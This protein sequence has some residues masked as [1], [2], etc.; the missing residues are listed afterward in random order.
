MGQNLSYCYCSKGQ[1]SLLMDGRLEID[2][3][4]P[5]FEENK[6]LPLSFD[7]HLTI[8]QILLKETSS[9]E[10]YSLMNLVYILKHVLND[11]D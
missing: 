5:T 9:R 1:K 11:I 3:G 2:L 7:S 6:L 8:E 10:Q 4:G